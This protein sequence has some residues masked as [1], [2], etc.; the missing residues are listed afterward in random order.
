MATYFK[1]LSSALLLTALCGCLG[2]SG[3]TSDP[4]KMGQLALITI[5]TSA[6]GLQSHYE[7]FQD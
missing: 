1:P 7:G 4:V 3:S 6:T 5:P 2:D